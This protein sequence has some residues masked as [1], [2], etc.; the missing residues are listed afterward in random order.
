[1]KEFSSLAENGHDSDI[2]INDIIDKF[3][4]IKFDK[5]EN[6]ERIEWEDEEDE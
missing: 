6:F 4:L 5:V 1:M 2:L 3:E